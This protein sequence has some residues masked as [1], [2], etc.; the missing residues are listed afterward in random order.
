MADPRPT[1]SRHMIIYIPGPLQLSPRKMSPEIAFQLCTYEGQSCLPLSRECHNFCM[2]DQ[3]NFY[4]SL[5]RIHKV[6]LNFL[7]LPRTL[8]GSVITIA[9]WTY[10]YSSLKWRDL[11]LGPESPYLLLGNNARLDSRNGRVYRHSTYCGRISRL[12]SSLK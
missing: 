7:Y 6:R 8:L 3:F 2:S 4:D 11:E 12:I 1:F 10:P 5:S 9:S